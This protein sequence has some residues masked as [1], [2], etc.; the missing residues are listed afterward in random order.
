MTTIYS[1][2]KEQK[3]KLN[4]IPAQALQ[5]LQEVFGM[6]FICEDGGIVAIEM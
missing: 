3:E 5:V 1:L 4:Q 6:R 2:T